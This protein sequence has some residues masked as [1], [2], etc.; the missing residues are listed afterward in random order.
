MPEYAFP[1]A[2]ILDD[3]MKRTAAL[4]DSRMRMLVF[5]LALRVAVNRGHTKASW[6]ISAADSCHN[7]VYKISGGNSC[8][9]R[10]GA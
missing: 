5:I 3:R 1:K 2:I 10:S 4:N 9:I 8:S 7:I 6:L